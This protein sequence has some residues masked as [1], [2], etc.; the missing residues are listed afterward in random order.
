MAKKIQKDSS[1]FQKERDNFKIQIQT[2]H[3]SKGLEYD[4]VFIPSLNQKYQSFEDK[5]PSNN[6]S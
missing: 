4:M 5:R 3:Q 6:S 1:K 2:S